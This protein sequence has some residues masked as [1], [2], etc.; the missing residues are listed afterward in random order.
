MQANL[1]YVA[2]VFALKKINEVLA[3][4]LLFSYGKKDAFILNTQENEYHA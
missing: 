2:N 4:M 3:V 1:S